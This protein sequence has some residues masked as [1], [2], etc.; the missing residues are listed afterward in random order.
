[1]H[2]FATSF[3]I[4]HYAGFSNSFL[5]FQVSRHFG[6]KF[7]TKPVSQNYLNISF[8]CAGNVKWEAASISCSLFRR[9]PIM[10]TLYSMSSCYYGSDNYTFIAFLHPFTETRAHARNRS[11]H[12]R[13]KQSL[14]L[15]LPV[16]TRPPLKAGYITRER[17]TLSSGF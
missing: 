3:T 13:L 8:I 7:H 2:V 11:N 5:H 15:G 17:R 6:N 12:P 16:I 14:G 10:L 9:E 1:M 4:N